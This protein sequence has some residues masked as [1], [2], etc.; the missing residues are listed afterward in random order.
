MATVYAVFERRLAM[1]DSGGALS[2]LFTKSED[3]E[4]YAA[5][6]AD[7]AYFAFEAHEVEFLYDYYVESWELHSSI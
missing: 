7:N 5:I 2:K 6:E 3:A 4:R 1:P